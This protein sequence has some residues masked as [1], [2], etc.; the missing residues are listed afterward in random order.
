VIKLALRGMA[1]RKLR[2]ILTAI[3]VLLGVAM[4]AGTYVLTDQIRNAFGELTE[5]ANEGTDA[6]LTAETEFTSSASFELEQLPG[7]LVTKVEALPGVAKAAGQAQGNGALIV[8]GE[9][10]R[11][12]GGAPNPIL[13]VLPEPFEVTEPVDGR[14]PENPGEVAIN[15]DQAEDNGIEVGDEVELETAIGKQPVTVVGLV[16]FG[17][18]GAASGYNFVTATV[19]DVQRWFEHEGEFSSILV[20]GKEGVTPRELVASLES[21]LPPGVQAET[22]EENAEETAEEISNSINSFLGPALLAF[23]GAALLVGAFIIFNTF[24]ISVA[25]RTREFASLRTLGATRLQI[26]GSVAFEALVIGI[27][28]AVAG[29]FLGFG[30]AKLLTQLFDA[31]G[32][33]IPTTGLV[34]KPRTVILALGIGI[35]VTLVASVGPAARAMR[36]PP[37]MALQEGARAPAPRYSRLAPYASGLV[38]VGGVAL[39]VTGLFGSGPA[40]NRLLSMAFGAVLL[41]V[42]LALVAKYI[43]RPVAGALGKPL[44]AAFAI[45]GRLARE[46]SQRNP[47]RTA[48]TAAALMVGLGLVVFVAVF[49]ASLKTSFGQQ[50]DRLITADLVISSDGFQPIPLRASEEA[51]RVDGVEETVNVLYDQVEV[52]GK[53]SNVIY[54]A[55]L[56]VE[57]DRLADVYAIDWIDGED[58]L[59]DELSG[60]KVLIEEQFAKARELDVGDDY[61]VATPSGGRARLTA[62]GM[63]KD[64][65]LMQGMIVERATLESIS[66]SRDPFFVYINLAPNADAGA[67]R[68]ELESVLEQFPVANVETI[69]GLREETEKQTDQIVYL[70]YALLAMSVVISLFGIANSLFLSIHER[71][72]EFGLLRAIGATRSQIRRMVRYESAITAAIGGVLGTIVGLVFAALIT[73]S[74]SEFGLIFEVPFGQLV[75]FLVLAVVVGVLAAVLPARR[76]S[77]LEPL[78]ALHYE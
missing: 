58:S 54:D 62:I 35:G 78:E 16:N 19:A 61:E 34:L 5:T 65:T 7:S 43:V 13:G 41:F 59:L 31:S 33:P 74:L 28:A 45:V 75:V 63:Y 27:A 36:V 69:Q 68:G 66:A 57:P 39:L 71:T 47:G 26:L 24:S 40:A 76:G 23:A 3:A 6:I 73:A 48:I 14:Q 12:E 50:I 8:D 77:R 4:I 9:A 64:P 29:L 42:G 49:A 37:A 22:G 52:D 10:I 56:G 46:N 20:A 21:A 70:L 38:S 1:Q 72:R 60:D 18:E 11:T 51:A 17:D 2:S 44:E 30:F 32:F 25:E 15:T 53:P 55:L 67:V